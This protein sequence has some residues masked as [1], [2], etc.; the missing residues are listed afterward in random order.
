MSLESRNVEY[1][2]RR[3]NWLLISGWLL[4]AAGGGCVEGELVVAGDGDVMA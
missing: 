2:M 1:R 3:K 4:R